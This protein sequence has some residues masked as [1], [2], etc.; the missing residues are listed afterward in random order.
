MLQ[1]MC[2]EALLSMTPFPPDGGGRIGLLSYTGPTSISTG[3]LFPSPPQ[4]PKPV[5]N[6]ICDL[7]ANRLCPEPSEAHAGLRNLPHAASVGLRKLPRHDWNEV[8]VTSRGP[9]W[10]LSPRFGTHSRLNLWTPNLQMK[11][12]HPLYRYWYRGCLC[13]DVWGCIHMVWYL[14]LREVLVPNE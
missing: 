12:N 7:L 13:G 9:Q 1:I 4:V 14:Q 8:L 3:D 2:K 6:Q 5:H 10:V 11:K